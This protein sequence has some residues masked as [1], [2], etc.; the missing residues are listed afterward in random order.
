MKIIRAKFEPIPNNFSKGMSDLVT[1]L[2]QKDTRKRPSCE[3]ILRIP[4]V[5]EKMKSLG[6]NQEK[7]NPI[8]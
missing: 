1:A 5:V 4:S 6:Y 2:L 7:E 3:E 8:Q